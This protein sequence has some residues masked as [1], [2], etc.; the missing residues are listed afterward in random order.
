MTTQRVVLQGRLVLNRDLAARRLLT[1]TEEELQR[2][3]LDIHDGPVQNIFA[4]LSQLSVLRTHLATLPEA[5]AECA[6]ILARTIKLLETSLDD[7]RHLLSTFRSPEFSARGLAEVL[8]ELAVQFETL[9]GTTV[10]LEMENVPEVALPIKIALYR[11]MQEALANVYRHAGV[12]SAQVRV[13]LDNGRLNLE[14]RDQGR[15]FEPP[16]LSGQ[17]A[18][19]RRE[20]IGLR[21]MRERAALVNGTLCIESRPGAGTCIRVEVQLND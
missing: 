1:V 19:E 2:I 9:T 13:W 6:V 10:S 7:I 4:A 8:E 5:P 18:T 11:I 20:H 3:V 14:V 16:P 21:G 12:K 15:G 17:D